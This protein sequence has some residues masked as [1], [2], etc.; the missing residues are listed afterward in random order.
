MT[1]TRLY[2]T[3]FHALNQKLTISL[4]SVNNTNV[5]SRLNAIIV[6]PLKHKSYKEKSGVLITLL[7][8][9]LKFFIQQVIENKIKK[10]VLNEN[11]ISRKLVDN[12][13]FSH[14]SIF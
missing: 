8:A 3:A 7:V 11:F 2:Q 5:I 4:Y 9:A 14:E 6:L 13:F 12:W 10:G 1:I